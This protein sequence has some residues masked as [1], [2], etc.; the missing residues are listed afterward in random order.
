ME[1]LPLFFQLRGSRVLLVGGGKVA[2]RK[3]RLLTRAGATVLCVSPDIDHELDTMLQKTGGEWRMSTYAPEHL[4][5]VTLV[6]A[7]T[8]DDA[9]NRGI[10][11][12]CRARNIPVNVV[13]S[14]DLCSF[15]FPSIVDRS[16]LVIGISSRRSGPRGT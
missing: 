8:P 2:L 4:D 9:V 10:A 3:A 7:A 5:G 11:E 14:P 12:D 1:F 13:D 6:V 15:V 16:P